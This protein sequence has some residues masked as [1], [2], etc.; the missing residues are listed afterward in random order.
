LINGEHRADV[1]SE[2]QPADS[3]WAGEG[4][5]AGRVFDRLTDYAREV[6]VLAQLEARTL[7]H[8]Y[9]GSEHLL[10]GLLAVPEGVGAQ[11]LGSFG[12]SLESVREQVAR[13]MRR[14]E[15]ASPEAIPFT[16]RA[17]RLLALAAEE[18][19]RLGDD[20]LG[21]EHILL[22]IADETEAVAAGILRALDLD[23]ARIPQAVTDTPSAA[24]ARTLSSAAEASTT[25]HNGGP[26]VTMTEI[27]PEMFDT[28][29]ELAQ[30]FG[31]PVIEPT[32]WPADT[33]EISHR[34]FRSP[35]GGVHYQVGST[36]DNGAPICVVGHPETALAGRTPRD[37]LTGEWSEPPEL[38]HLRG[39]IGKVGIPR[40]LQAAIYDQGVQLQLIGY[41][42]EEEIMRTVDS[43]R[44][45]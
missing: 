8:D 20:H 16:P 27:E 11:A 36:R 2:G 28:A 1:P 19:L 21:T 26:R 13:T 3:T 44:P 42:T 10:L 40:R 38:A 7:K 41:E 31:L 14:G 30:A 22:A 12:I 43:L 17:K 6:V 23:L 15:R 4:C 9:V 33:G 29:P 39:L 37:W 24:E 35:S 45:V 34:L 18:A 5:D 32:W 25:A